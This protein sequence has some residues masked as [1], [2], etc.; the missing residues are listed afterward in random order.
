MNWTSWFSQNDPEHGMN[1]CYTITHKLWGGVLRHKTPPDDNLLRY[2]G[3]TPAR[4][5][6]HSVKAGMAE[7]GAANINTCSGPKHKRCRGHIRSHLEQGAARPLPLSSAT[8][9]EA[10]L[11]RSWLQL[12]AVQ[13]IVAPKLNKAVGG[14]CPVRQVQAPS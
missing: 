14:A 12:R 2:S 9:R 10:S 1:K 5:M 13:V 11:Q 8:G 6:D 4:K 7:T 3:Q